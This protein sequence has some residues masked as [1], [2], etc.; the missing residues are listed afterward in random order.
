[1]KP[2]SD[3][4]KQFR[5]LSREEKFK[6]VLAMCNELGTIPKTYS[7]KNHTPSESERV[8]G[9]FFINMQSAMN[10]GRLPHMYNDYIKAISEYGNRVDI[11]NKIDLVYVFF[12]NNKRL[13]THKSDDVTL[14]NQWKSIKSLDVKAHSTELTRGRQT[15]LTTMIEFSAHAMPKSK[16]EKLTDLLNFCIENNRTPKQHSANPDEKKLADFLS[17]IKQSIKTKPLPPELDILFHRITSFAPPPRVTC[18]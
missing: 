3:T 11:S 10:R 18:R 12:R 14:M 9:Q 2:H 1:M 17:T 5:A 13:P 6:S 4:A 15:K 8:H 7:T 16:L